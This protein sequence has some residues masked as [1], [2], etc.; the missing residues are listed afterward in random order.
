MAKLPTRTSARR[1]AESLLLQS[2]KRA[3]GLK[4]EQD[5]EYEAIVLK[6]T[7]GAHARRLSIRCRS[8]G[9]GNANEPSCFSEERIYI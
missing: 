8:F 5:R 1:I 3:S 7:L 2:M 9:Q 6:T 4:Q